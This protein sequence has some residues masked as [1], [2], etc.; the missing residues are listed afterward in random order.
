[1]RI[2]RVSLIEPSPKE[3]SI[4]SIVKQPRLGAVI[5]ATILKNRG[6]ETKVFSEFITYINWDYVFNSDLV[7]ISTP[8]FSA[9]EA[10]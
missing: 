1:M 10:Y 6:Y 5:L 7:G 8:T 9:D 4:W 3:A 2:K